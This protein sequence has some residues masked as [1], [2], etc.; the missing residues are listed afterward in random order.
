[1]RTIGLIGGM[2]WEST[3]IYYRTV[4]RLVAASLGGLHS[5]KVLLQSLDF[6]D[7]V[8]LQQAGRWDEAGEL[9]GKAGR[10]LELIARRLAGM[11]VNCVE[12]KIAEIFRAQHMA[13]DGGV[14]QRSIGRD[15]DTHAL[16][17][18]RSVTLVADI[19]GETGN[20]MLAERPCGFK[21]GCFHGIEEKGASIGAG[22]AG[23]HLD[24]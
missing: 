3:A 5:A 12:V 23:G 10:N 4:N 20:D 1:M 19:R 22:H 16:V 18:Q 2:S 11:A 14:I 24:R 6:G 9:I 15:L 17:L 21:Q 13:D 8:R 7:I